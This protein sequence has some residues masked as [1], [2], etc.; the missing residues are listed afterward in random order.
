M[1]LRYDFLRREPATVG[2][3][4]LDLVFGSSDIVIIIMKQGGHDIVVLSQLIVAPL[5][6]LL[7]L[8]RRLIAKV[9][10]FT[11]PRLVVVPIRLLYR[12]VAEVILHS[13]TTQSAKRSKPKAGKMM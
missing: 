9:V 3:I 13:F 7:T 12:L 5:L 4:Y 2:I 10:L 6:C 11:L 1:S 8:L